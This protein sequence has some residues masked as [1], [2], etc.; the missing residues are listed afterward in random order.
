MWRLLCVMVAGYWMTVGGAALA[1]DPPR[2]S[3]PDI[4]SVVPDLE[5]P[6]LSA[7]PPAAGK[8]VKELL[9]AWKNNDAVYHVLY[10]P[11]DWQPAARLPVLVEYAGNG[12]YS[13]AFGDVSGGRPEGSRLGYGLSGG[14][15]FIWVC[16]PYLNT[17]GDD[18]AIHW[19]GDKPTYDP[20]PTLRYCRAAVEHVCRQW[21][22]DPQRVVLCG[23]SRGAIACN[24]L[25]L[26]DDETARLW[27]AFLAY[28]HYD[29]LRTWPYP[30][31][32]QAAALV[33]LARLGNRP[34][35]LCSEGGR[36]AEA[37]R[38]LA[39]HAPQ[40]DFVFTGTG[41]RNH[42]DA[43]VLRPSPARELAREWLR[44]VTEK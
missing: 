32:D 38:Y 35:F 26:H 1:A 44:R 7:W 22:G 12:G 23:F 18:I 31:S 37:Q 6:E 33:R 15:G 3:L 11:S 27:R 13:N 41:F 20:Q 24:F 42:N 2:S 36:P 25:G 19:W 14:R 29:G 4:S 5:I 39:Q 17:A 34:Q 16:L 43:W 28:S 30:G 10:L 8:R 9:A 21:G 40:G